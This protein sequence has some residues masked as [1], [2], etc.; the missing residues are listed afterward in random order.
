MVAVGY[1]LTLALYV[2]VLFDISKFYSLILSLMEFFSCERFLQ[3]LIL[4]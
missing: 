4:L 3:I 1:C 2:R